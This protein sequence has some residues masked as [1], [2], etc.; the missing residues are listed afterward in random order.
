MNVLSGVVFFLL[1]ESFTRRN[2]FG[3]HSSISDARIVPVLECDEL[4]ECFQTVFVNILALEKTLTTYA[5]KMSGLDKVTQFLSQYSQIRQA[6]TFPLLF[7]PHEVDEE[8]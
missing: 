4:F 7:S 2:S 6:K 1:L 8:Q 5:S 3:T